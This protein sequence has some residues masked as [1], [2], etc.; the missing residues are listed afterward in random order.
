M[1]PGGQ[2]SSIFATPLGAMLALFSLLGASCSHFVPL[3]A[4]V[5]AL[6]RFWCVLGRSGLDFG[7]S[8]EG[9]G[10]VLER[11]STYFSKLLRACALAVSACSEC[12][13]TTVLLDRNT[14]LLG[15]KTLRKQRAPR[16]KS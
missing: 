7:G 11:P 2:K 12:N 4:F 5:A 9:P 1:G 16:K 15:R 13:K 14:V 3:A 10:M 8:R 6:G